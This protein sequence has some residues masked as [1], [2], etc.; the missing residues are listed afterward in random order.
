MNSKNGLL[1]R[2]LLVAGLAAYAL[3][4]RSDD[5]ADGFRNPPASARP[6]TWW[7]WMNGNVSKEGIT[8]D[9]EAIAA[10]GLG[11]VYIFDAGCEIPPGPVAFNTPAW[12][13]HIRF[14]VA[15][16]R[17]L[18]LE[19]VI[20]NCS[21]W[22]SSG[23]PWIAPSNSMKVVVTSETPVAGGAR[24]RG[25]LPLAAK[26]NGFYADIAVLAIP[27]VG[28]RQALL[29]SGETRTLDAHGATG[30][31]VSF[32]LDR[33]FAATALAVNLEPD[34]WLG[35]HAARVIVETRGED[36]AWTRADEVVAPLAIDSI[37]LK[38]VRHLPFRRPITAKAWR[39]TFVPEKVPEKVKT[40]ALTELALVNRAVIPGF[41]GKTFRLRDQRPFPSN[42]S[43]GPCL[44]K[45]SALDLTARVT[46]DGELDWT[47]PKG[48]NWKVLRIG[49]VSNGKKNHPA[50]RFGEG[51]EVDKL[52]R[53]ALDFHF[54]AY[55]G[56]LCRALGDLAGDHASGLVG[57]LVDSYEIGCQNW[58]QGM[59]G[60]FRRRAGYDIRPF[61]PVLCGYVVG[62]TEET[63]RFM[64]DFRR[65]VAALF[66]ENYPGALREKCRQYGLKFS[67]EPYGNEPADD[68][69]YAYYCDIPMSEFWVGEKDNRGTG[70]TPLV[71]SAAHVYGKRIMGAEAFTCSPGPWGGKWQNDPWSLKTQGDI[72]YADGINR[73][74]YHRFTH[75]PWAAD[76]T[77]RPGM[78]MGQWGTHFDRTNT[79]WPYVKPFIAYQTRCQYL[80]QEGRFVADAA[81]FIGDSMPQTLSPYDVRLLPFGYRYDVVNPRGAAMIAPKDHPILFLREEPR[82]AEG[83]AAIEKARR[84]GVKVCPLADAAKV[85]PPPD[86]TC[87]GTTDEVFYVHRE[88]DGGTDGY[89][90]AYPNRETPAELRLSFRVTGRV[91]EFWRPET[92]EVERVRDWCEKDGRT[93]LTW[94]ARQGDAVFVM[95][96]PNPTDRVERVGRVT[97]TVP[98][99]GPWTLTLPD[100]RS[101]TLTELVSWTEIDDPDFR[102]FSGTATY[103]AQLA[104]SGER[105]ADARIVLD[106][107]EVKNIAE[108]I[109][110]GRS[111]ILW[112]PPFKADLTAAF[113]KVDSV[114]VRIKVTNLWPNRLIGDDFLPEDCAWK[115]PRSGIVELPDWVKAGKPSPTGRKTFNTWKHWTTDDALL[116]SGLLGPVGLKFDIITK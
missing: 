77:Y 84:A 1:V 15:E 85:L 70:V 53:A 5:L 108:V 114:R 60:E 19:V 47:A 91:P 86:F 80:L 6:H 113:A 36:G 59:E 44:P 69:D 32:A 76:R 82:R 112:K 87:A 107:G 55:V 45:G 63:E 12:D 31:T 30:N 68:L 62:S 26:T 75:Q 72:A 41:E 67:L 3:S 101:K 28:T 94:R 9:L 56:K 54:E 39:F 71:S 110:G 100:G 37:V 50:S 78:T 111:Q 58:T 115:A 38:D 29:A 98:V 105:A 96:R 92:G 61:F 97:R 17:R 40:I 4:A 106:L 103:E 79:W 25:R 104:L 52:S 88:Y 22:S 65:V 20:P 51:L 13:E 93:H 14:A 7:H 48:G 89:F 95:F 35:Q 102:Y 16:A 23:G 116:P 10:A 34:E 83:K 90:V 11:G 21:G 49:Y 73:I 8:A 27:D 66:C 74:I 81:V 24:F 46:A 2:V 99:K 18:G 64:D 42:P 109:V 57:T 43:L 33:P